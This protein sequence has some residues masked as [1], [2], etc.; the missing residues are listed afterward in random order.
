MTGQS[1]ILKLASIIKLLMDYPGGLSMLL[2]ITPPPSCAA[3]EEMFESVRYN[4]E[5][6]LGL[7]GFPMRV[8]GGNVI[9]EFDGDIRINNEE[10]FNSVIASCGG[11]EHVNNVMREWV[12]RYPRAWS[13][14]IDHLC[15]SKSRVDNMNLDAIA[16]KNQLSRNSVNRILNDFPQELAT[17]ILKVPALKRVD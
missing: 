4:P 17:A 8:S 6:T 3:I 7:D 13:V 16:E 2:G 9:K 14:I 15:W 1:L 11:W 12:E 5:Q 10:R